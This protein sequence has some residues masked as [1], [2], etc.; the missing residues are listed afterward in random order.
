MAFQAA[1]PWAREPRH[2]GSVP[3]ACIRLRPHLHDEHQPAAHDD[4]HLFVQ[5]ESLHVARHASR[6]RTVFTSAVISDSIACPAATSDDSIAM[7]A[8][9]DPIALVEA[10]ETSS[11]A[12]GCRLPRPAGW[13]VLAHSPDALLAVVDERSL[14]RPSQC[15]A[16]LWYS[17]DNR[18]R[19]CEALRAYKAD[20]AAARGWCAFDPHQLAAPRPPQA[21]GAS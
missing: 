2:P 18:H 14:G 3:N 16:A 15:W 19:H 12:R 21:R 13:T 10:E 4:K 6:P 7:D 5:S 1:A 9:M 20:R 17:P 8:A 11:S